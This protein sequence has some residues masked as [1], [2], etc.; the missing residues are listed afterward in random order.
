MMAGPDD[1]STGALVRPAAEVYDP[2]NGMFWGTL[3]MNVNREGHTAT[4][5]ASGKVLIAGGVDSGDSP[6]GE[7]ELY[8]PDTNAF[9][10]TGGT[11]EGRTPYGRQ[12]CWLMARSSG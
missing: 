11:Q 7:A 12:P 2:T 4:L 8:D 3:D 5:L 1:P 6:I 9:T 10:S